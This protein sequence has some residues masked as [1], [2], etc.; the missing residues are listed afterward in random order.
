ML[1]RVYPPGKKAVKK[2]YEDSATFLR[3]LDHL[4]S[5]KR[6]QKLDKVSFSSS[7]AK[8]LIEELSGVTYL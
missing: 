5:I 4:E 8:K 1:E 3:W 6:E 7:E 2:R